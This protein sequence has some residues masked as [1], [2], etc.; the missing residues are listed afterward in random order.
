MMDTVASQAALEPKVISH[1]EPSFLTVG[2][3]L[4]WKTLALRCFSPPGRAGWSLACPKH[5]GIAG[6]PISKQTV[7]KNRVLIAVLI[8]EPSIR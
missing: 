1:L 7:K 3:A 5:T 4:N 6:D 2:L 8:D